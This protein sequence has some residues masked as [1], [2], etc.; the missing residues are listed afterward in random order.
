[1]DFFEKN[2]LEYVT[3]YN[4][5]EYTWLYDALYVENRLDETIL[6]NLGRQFSYAAN[7]VGLVEHLILPIED[8]MFLIRLYA[9]AFGGWFDHDELYMKAGGTDPE[10]MYDEY[11]IHLMPSEC[12]IESFWKELVLLIKT[13]NMYHRVNQYKIISGGQLDGAPRI[14]VYVSGKINAQIVL[15]TIYDKFKNWPA[16]DQQSPPLFNQRVNDL[17]YI[18]QGNREDKLDYIFSYKLGECPVYELPDLIYY[19]D[20]YHLVLPSS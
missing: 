5:V 6:T 12:T 10:N 7:L 9:I 17:I 8:K 16:T 20:T 2:L 3:K 15:N 13:D 14:V 11:K 4:H 1:M 18:A 19:N